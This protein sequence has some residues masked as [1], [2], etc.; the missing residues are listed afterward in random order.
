MASKIRMI[1]VETTATVVGQ[2]DNGADLHQWLITTDTGFRAEVTECPCGLART[3]GSNHDTG[4]VYRAPLAECVC[5]SEACQ[6]RPVSQSGKCH[7][8]HRQRVERFAASV[9]KTEFVQAGVAA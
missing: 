3:L 9:A 5:K 2:A 6:R 8:W 7:G 1:A 4:E